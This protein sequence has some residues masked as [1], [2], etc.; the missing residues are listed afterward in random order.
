MPG[1]YEFFAG[2]GMVRAG[3]GA[4]W[5]CLFANDF[6]A[7]K[8]LTYQANWGTGGELTVGDIRAL[9]AA[10]LPG[11]PDLVWGSFPCQDLSLAGHGAGLAGER[12]GT[13]Y[14][15]WD[16]VRGLAADGRAPRLV[17]VENVCGA[18]TSRSGADFEAMARTFVEAGYRFGALVIN[19]DLFVPQS[20]PRLFVIGV[21][22]G[23]AIA[24]D[25][26]SPGP[27]APF[28]TPAVVRAVDRLPDDLR[29]SALWW[30]LPAPERRISTFADL[31]EDRPD[32]VAWHTP[33][34][35]D[36]LLS[37]MSPVNLAKVQAARRA[38]RRMVGGV[39][40]RTRADAAGVKTQRAEVRFDDVAG[41]LRTPS[42]GSS[43]QTL[44]VVDGP[45]TRSRLISARET[46]RLM[47]LPDSY[48]LPRSYT[49]A[50]HLTGDGVV[51]PVARHLARYLFEPLVGAANASAKAA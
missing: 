5:D 45:R 17:A 11:R 42:G 20:R 44:L 7:R 6:D 14:A 23:A 2:G 28:H 18:L 39:Y 3:L 25:L 51:V 29:T 31:I 40:R 46:A 30:N 16:L 33:A 12:S 38:G 34:E 22:A 47:G 8:G 35:T 36:R 15:F 48:L 27:I 43:R 13:F 4:G 26:T 21:H 32:S 10:A 1:F 19:A 49:D 24:A 37:L 50:Y 41:C 9:E